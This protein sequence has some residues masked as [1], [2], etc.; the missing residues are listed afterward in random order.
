MPGN[1]RH[2]VQCYSFVDVCSCYHDVCS[3]SYF[4][5]QISLRLVFSIKTSSLYTTFTRLPNFLTASNSS[6]S[7][8]ISFRPPP[9]DRCVI[10]ISNP[11]S[12]CSNLKP[13]FS[14]N[15]IALSFS[16]FFESVISLDFES[17]TTKA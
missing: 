13:L 3:F 15:S 11:S 16:V 7:T 9:T 8:N 14:R 2:G 4:A 6:D 10:L 1:H 5:I 17:T 12:D